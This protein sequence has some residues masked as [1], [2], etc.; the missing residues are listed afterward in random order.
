[1]TGRVLLADDDH[2][3]LRVLEINLAARGYQVDVAT[4]GEAALTRAMRHPDLIVLDLGLPDLDG[5]EVI[6]S[7]RVFSD[8]PILAISA[9]DDQRAAAA[10]RAG[11][12]DYLAKPFSIDRLVTRV[13]AALNHS[14]GEGAG[15]A[16]GCAMMG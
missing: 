1:M 12:D 14:P 4:T 7:V 9:Q 8:V 6:A 16:A 10:L 5:T 3:L 11:A 2:A 13:R 15:N